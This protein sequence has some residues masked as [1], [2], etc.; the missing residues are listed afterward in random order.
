M[1]NADGDNSWTE[2]LYFKVLTTRP[3]REEIFNY[4]TTNILELTDF[5]SYIQRNNM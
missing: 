4:A 3:V 1:D 5:S 2:R